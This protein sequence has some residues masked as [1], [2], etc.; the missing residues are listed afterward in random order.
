LI[1][2]MK[3]A[4]ARL[5]FCNIRV[6]REEGSEVHW[7]ERALLPLTVVA[8]PNTSKRSKRRRYLTVSH[9]RVCQEFFCTTRWACC[10]IGTLLERLP[11]VII[12][13]R[14]A[15]GASVGSQLLDGHQTTLVA[16]KGGLETRHHTQVRF[17]WGS[18]QN[19]FISFQ[20]KT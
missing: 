16:L 2:G 13:K 14:A 1:K 12:P 6:K 5:A 10:A 11:M 7:G 19:D 20:V 8:F 15:H 17:G 18:T 3:I 9:P 4:Q